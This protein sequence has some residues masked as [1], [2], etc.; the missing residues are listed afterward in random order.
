[1]TVCEADEPG[2]TLI[3]K[4]APV[5]VPE[6]MRA[7]GTTDA[8]SVKESIPLRTPSA[9][10]A[11][12]TLTVQAFPM[13]RLDPQSLVSAKSPLAA[14]LVMASGAAPPLVRVKFCSELV[15]SIP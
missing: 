11:K 7:C 3:R 14:M 9:V 5:P 12:A 8:L 13:L 6:R 1:M 4:P 15:V 2:A 10:G